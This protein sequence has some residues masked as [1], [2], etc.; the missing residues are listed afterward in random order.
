MFETITSFLNK[1]STAIVAVAT[2]IIAVATVLTWWVLSRQLAQ[3][4]KMI[5]LSRLDQRAWLG[6]VSGTELSIQEN[7]PVMF[8]FVVTNS[9]KSPALAST[10]IMAKSFR[11]SEFVPEY[12]PSPED[13][14]HYGG[15]GLVMPGMQIPLTTQR[16]NPVT[17]EAIEE[18]RTGHMVLYIYGE[19]TY[20]DIFN[21]PHYTHF[22]VFVHPTLDRVSFCK[23]YND[24]N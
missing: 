12:P 13:L 17:R 11:G 24:A 6:V 18:L 5:E 10:K 4:N 22:C 2:A 3:T 21:Q 23:T 16:T 1:N 19:I 8:Q 9:G 15:V 7:N 20:K 14:P